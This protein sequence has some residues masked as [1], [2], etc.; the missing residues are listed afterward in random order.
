MKKRLINILTVICMAVLFTAPATSWSSDDATPAPDAPLTDDS[1]K[2]D[3]EHMKP[4]APLTGTF[5]RPFSPA[6]ANGNPELFSVVF[7]PTPEMIS[8][9]PGLEKVQSCTMVV[10]G[11]IGSDRKGHLRA[12]L[13]KCNDKVLDTRGIFYD[14]NGNEGFELTEDGYIRAGQVFTFRFL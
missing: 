10:T 8:Q 13:L 9:V 5:D 2:P 11:Y 1:L 12:N 3:P 14:G 7:Y 6:D 4:N